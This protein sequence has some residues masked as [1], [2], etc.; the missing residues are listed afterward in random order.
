MVSVRRIILVLV[1]GAWF[2]QALFAQTLKEFQPIVEQNPIQTKA[3]HPPKFKVY[4]SE[5]KS[6]A[7]GTIRLYQIFIATQDMSV[8]NFTPSCSHF[9]EEAFQT[10]SPFR[11]LLLA[12]DRLLRDNPSVAGHYPINRKTGRFSDPLDFYLKLFK[13]PAKHAKTTKRRK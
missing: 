1:L 10:V 8:C 11:A 3:A 4:P 5:F 6:L 13:T 12:S 2:S 9:A 7:L